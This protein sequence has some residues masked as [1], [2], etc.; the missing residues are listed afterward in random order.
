MSTSRMKNSRSNRCVMSF[1]RRGLKPLMIAFMIGA[2]G[3]FSTANEERYFD[4]V[5]S[6]DPKDPANSEAQATSS[7]DDGFFFFAGFG[8]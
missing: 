1:E 7:D 6:G 3:S 2:I 8:G 4:A 5:L